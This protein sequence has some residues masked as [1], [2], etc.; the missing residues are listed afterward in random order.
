MFLLNIVTKA[1]L[2]KLN[3]TSSSDSWY[4]DALWKKLT[5]ACFI[6][7]VLETINTYTTNAWNK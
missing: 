3:S 4:F 1:K 6:Q 2:D 7:I 5:R